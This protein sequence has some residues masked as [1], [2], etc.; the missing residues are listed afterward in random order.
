M[1]PWIIGGALVGIVAAVLRLRRQPSPV[2][3]PAEPP[4]PIPP[5]VRAELDDKPEFWLDRF[6]QALAAVGAESVV[7]ERI[8]TRTW[9]NELVMVWEDR[10]YVD[11]PCSK[12]ERIC[13]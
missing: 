3:L 10:G 11:C 1:D 2:D 5:S 7:G 13:R 12:C 4:K 9:A 8:E 6:H